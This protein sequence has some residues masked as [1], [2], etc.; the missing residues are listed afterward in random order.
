MHVI[1]RYSFRYRQLGGGLS[2]IPFDN[3]ASHVHIYVPSCCWVILWTIFYSFVNN[4]C[5]RFT[6]FIGIKTEL[7]L[8]KELLQL[9]LYM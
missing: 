2:Y 1:C 3:A 8:V 6:D 7:K 5:L 4:V 9:M